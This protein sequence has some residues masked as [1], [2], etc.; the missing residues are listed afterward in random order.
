KR[1]ARR[2][3]KSVDA[4]VNSADVDT[5]R[6]AC[7]DYVDS[8]RKS[9]REA[10]ADDAERRFA[11]TVDLDPLGAVKLAHLRERH[12]EAWRERMETGHLPELPK[13]RG[14]SPLPRPLS[15]ASF[16][17]TLAAL[18]AALNHA[19]RR[20]YVSPEKAIE[21]ASV[22]P[23]K[24]ADQ[25]RDLYLARGQR[26][27]LLDAADGPAR[28]LMEC[29]ILTGCRPGDPAGVLR[30]D[31]DARTASV[32]FRA[33]TGPRTIPLSPAAKALLDRVAK[34]KLPTAHLFAQQDGSPWQASAWGTAVREAAEAAGLRAGVTLYEL[35]HCWITDA[36]V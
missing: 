30:R 29:V 34:D 3:R 17:R 6:A 35:R 9:K 21:W 25:R 20:R 33:K 19:V 24:G 14:R 11:R 5:V 7:A 12:L 13:L 27:A 31:Y 22:Q 28:D 15:P 36:I 32:T 4:G 8:L 26:R 16:K 2:W 23:A 1:E 10:A 18:K